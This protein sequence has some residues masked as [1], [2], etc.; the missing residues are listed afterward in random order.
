MKV[1]H[2]LV[3]IPRMAI[4]K[5]SETPAKKIRRLQAL[6]MSERVSRALDFMHQQ[7]IA[8]IACS[9]RKAAAIYGAKRSSVYDRYKGRKTR[10]EA[11]M[12]RQILTE[13]QESVL[14]EWIKTWGYHGAPMN[15]LTIRAKARALSGQN[16]GENWVY[17][18]MRRHP[19]LKPVWAKKLDAARARGL[20]P[21]VVADFFKTL[22][23]ELIT[24][25][26]PAQNIFN[27]DEKGVMCGDDAPVKVFVDRNQRTVSQVT[28]QDRELTTVMEC[29]CADGTAIPPMIIFKGVK[30]KVEWTVEN[31]L[32]MRAA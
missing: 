31:D 26:I 19:D 16:V 1:L 14:V 4:I 11:Q 21:A 29:V 13:Q 25:G 18:F 10:Q 17:R 24:H 8:G 9:V 27:A 32:G 15:N 7:E 30:K 5:Q 12:K 3:I 2:P 28:Q 22:I 23:A 6:E 20:N